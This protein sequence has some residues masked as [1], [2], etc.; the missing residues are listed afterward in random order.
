ML[1]FINLLK[2][3]TRNAEGGIA[4]ADDDIRKRYSS[5]RIPLTEG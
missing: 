1:V 2:I 4:L 5:F 3:E